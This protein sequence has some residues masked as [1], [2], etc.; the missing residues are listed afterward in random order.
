MYGICT[1]IYH[2]NQPNVGKYS[3]GPTNILFFFWRGGGVPWKTQKTPTWLAMATRRSTGTW[4][5]GPFWVLLDGNLKS[6]GQPGIFAETETP[7][8]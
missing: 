4:R 7:I 6:Q 5:F 3:I 2:K 8:K 1:Y